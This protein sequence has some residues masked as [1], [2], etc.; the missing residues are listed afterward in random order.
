MCRCSPE[1][2]AEAQACLERVK[3]AL[4]ATDADLL[5]R[6]V[7]NL[8]WCLGEREEHFYGYLSE[9]VCDQWCGVSVI[10]RTYG[11]RSHAEKEDYARIWV[12]CDNV[13][14]GLARAWE[15]AE[16]AVSESK[17]EETV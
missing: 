11:D 4:G 5:T 13:E 14:D 6:I 2:E 7:W 1:S 8:H 10:V 15:L 17:Q 12:Q 3:E 16:E 9:V